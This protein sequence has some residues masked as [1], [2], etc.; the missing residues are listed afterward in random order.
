MQHGAE[1]ASDAAPERIVLDLRGV[2]PPQ[3]ILTIL[4]KVSELPK[5]AILE[6]RLDAN[7]MQLYDLL[8]QRGFQLLVI[9]QK[10]GSFV[11]E[12]KARKV[13]PH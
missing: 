4:Q 7:P 5:S 1:T 12:V 6:V 13:A 8:Q 9:E 11:G 10:D 3:P 2:E